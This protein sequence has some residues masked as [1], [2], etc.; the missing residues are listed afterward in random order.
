[1]SQALLE[2]DGLRYTQD[3]T[4]AGDPEYPEFSAVREWELEQAEVKRK[5]SYVVEEYEGDY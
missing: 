5:S 4:V 2:V 3:L 1:M